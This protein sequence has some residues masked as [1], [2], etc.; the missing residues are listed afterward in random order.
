MRSTGS[1]LQNAYE[2]LGLNPNDWDK[3]TAQD[4]KDAYK[5]LAV[6][7]HPDKPGGSQ[8]QFEAVY[9][10]YKAVLSLRGTEKDKPLPCGDVAARVEGWRSRP[11]PHG[12]QPTAQPPYQPAQSR[13]DSGSKRFDLREFNESFTR[14]STPFDEGYGDVFGTSSS[15]SS[16][17]SLSRRTTTTR[18]DVIAPLPERESLAAA[19]PTSRHLIRFEHPQPLNSMT[20]GITGGLL[21]DSVAIEDF[22]GDNLSG[23][24][25]QFT[26]VMLAHSTPKIAEESFMEGRQHFRTVDEL[27]ACRESEP[28]FR[29]KNRQFSKPPSYI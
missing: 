14:D 9:D 13:G 28:Y 27:L 26:D 24:R 21:D 17:S 4:L 19:T 29:E 20:V 25:L 8:Q 1:S 22:S 7:V 23:K 3:Y 6:Q 16:S 11:Q 18:P 15:S 2:V 10:A 5:R 12:H